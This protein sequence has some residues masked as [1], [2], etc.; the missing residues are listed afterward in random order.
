MKQWAFS[1]VKPIIATW[2]NVRALQLTSLTK[3]HIA[4]VF[5]VDPEVVQAIN[6]ELK[7]Q[8]L[9]EFDKLKI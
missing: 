1:L 3:N 2:L 8:A 9:A 6:D 4:Q 7:K 5:K